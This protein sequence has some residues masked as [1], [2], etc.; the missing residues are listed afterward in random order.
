MRAKTITEMLAEL[1]QQHDIYAV[2]MKKA[3]GGDR[4]TMTKSCC[5]NISVR[6]LNN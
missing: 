3:Q 5:V 4:I 2:E 1:Q 6:R